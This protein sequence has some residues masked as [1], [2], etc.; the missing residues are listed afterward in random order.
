M[1]AVKCATPRLELPMR[2]MHTSAQPMFASLMIYPPMLAL[3][4]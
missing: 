4:L 2:G 1:L 3:Y